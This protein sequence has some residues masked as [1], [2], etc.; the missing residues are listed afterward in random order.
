MARNQWLSNLIRK[1]EAK[2]LELPF[3]L[4]QD[5]VIRF[6]DENLPARRLT[7]IVLEA[8]TFKKYEKGSKDPTIRKAVSRTLNLVREGVRSLND[9]ITLELAQIEAIQDALNDWEAPAPMWSY[10]E[11]LRDY[12][13]ERVT[14][15]RGLLAERKRRAEE[16]PETEP[17]NGE[18]RPAKAKSP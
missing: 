6:G 14:T 16:A 18:R 11:T 1:R 4:T 9:E 5:Y 12:V 17:K 7:E 2:M 10:L 3:R 15:G 13:N 8:A